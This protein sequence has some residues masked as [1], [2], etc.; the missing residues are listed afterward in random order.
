MPATD[1]LLAAFDD[2]TPRLR[3]AW[4]AVHPE[5]AQPPTFCIHQPYAPG[6]KPYACEFHLRQ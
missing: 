3:D 1:P 6:M 4:N 2:G 5:D